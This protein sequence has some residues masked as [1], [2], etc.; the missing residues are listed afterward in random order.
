MELLC[1]VRRQLHQLLDALHEI[2]PQGLQLDGV[3]LDLRQLPNLGL[4]ERAVR[5]LARHLYTG[6]SLNEKTNGTI[7]K[8]QHL[9]DVARTTNTVKVIES[10]LLN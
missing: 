9:Q 7:R 2:A 5:H 4:E 6:Q 10:R 3:P 8:S 1:Q